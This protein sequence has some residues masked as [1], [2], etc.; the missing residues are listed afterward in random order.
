[1]AID[2]NDRTTQSLLPTKRGPGRPRVSQED[3]AAQLK[4][5]QKV[6]KDKRLADGCQRVS[7]WLNKESLSAV[8]AE[9]EKTGCGK[10]EAVNRLIQNG[11]NAGNT[12][13]RK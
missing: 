6:L 11:A 7:L 8:N 4:R 12:N 1:M 13:Y 9:M 2:T 3:K 10:E 5:A